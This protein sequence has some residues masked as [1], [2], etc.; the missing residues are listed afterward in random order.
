MRKGNIATSIVIWI[1]VVVT[2]FFYVRNYH[3]LKTIGEIIISMT[4]AIAFFTITILV[5]ARDKERIYQAKRNEEFFIMTKL[6]W[7][8][9]MI[10]DV[11]IY[12]T[13]AVIIF[14]PTFFGEFPSISTFAQAIIAFG[15]LS[16][17]KIL[18]LKQ[19]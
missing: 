9:A 15:A 10:H 5:Y 7:R 17:L 4:P 12:L 3:Q 8:Q 14:T 16:Y 1:I 19:L 18:Y 13:P 6:N 11:L 2:M